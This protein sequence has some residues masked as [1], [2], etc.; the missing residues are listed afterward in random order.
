MPLPTLLVTTSAPEPPIT[1][2]KPALLPSESNVAVLP[3]PM[4]TLRPL[5]T[6]KLPAKSKVPLPE[7]VTV[8]LTLVPPSAPSELMLNAPLATLTPPV[9]FPQPLMAKVPVPFFVMPKPELPS[10]T[11]ASDS[12]AA[13][14]A[15]AVGQ[16]DDEIAAERRRAEG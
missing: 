8:V 14:A 7:K 11:P 4:E 5:A 2:A 3:P 6:V 9:K 1:P 10:L 15:G 16:A 12:V 13:A